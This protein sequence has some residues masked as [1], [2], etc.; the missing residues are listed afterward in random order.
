MVGKQRRRRWVTGKP[1]DA[2]KQLTLENLVQELLFPFLFV[3][4]RCSQVVS[5]NSAE[6][7]VRKS[8]QDEQR[9]LEL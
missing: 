8:S 5:S 2:G 4:F 9:Q 7:V 1:V 3:F 6:S